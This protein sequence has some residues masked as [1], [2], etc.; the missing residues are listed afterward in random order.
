MK[1][2]FLVALY[3]LPVISYAADSY[4]P[5]AG[6]VHMP[7]VSVGKDNYEVDMLDQGSLVFK[8][9]SAIPTSTLS[10]STDIYDSASGILHMP[11]VIV[12]SNDY[13]VDMI[14][15][16]ELVFK[17]TSA[18][19]I[20]STTTNYLNGDILKVVEPRDSSLNFTKNKLEIRWKAR[21]NYFLDHGKL[22][23]ID[24]ETSMDQQHVY[25]YIPDILPVLDEYGIAIM[26]IDGCQRPSDGSNGYRWS[27]YIFDLV[28]KYPEYFIPT[29]NG[30]TNNNWLKQKMGEYSSFINQLETEINSNKYYS[31]GELDF[32]HYMS[33]HQCES[34]RNDRDNDI[35][36]D[37]ENG[38]RVFQL[39]SD[40][41]I[42]FVMH[43]EAED[44]ALI[45]LE[46][47]LGEYPKAKVI[48]AHFSQ[49]RHPEKQQNF[50]PEYVHH[51]LSSY[52]NLY[53]DL[54]IGG[55]N[56]KYNCAGPDNNEVLIG[57]TVI[58]EEVSGSQENT[59]KADY[60]KILTEFSDR[61]VYASDYGT[62]RKP[63]PIHLKNKT[64]NFHNIIKNLPE[65]A[66]H[67]IAYKNAWFLL[68][69]HN[70]SN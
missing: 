10:T 57:D 22:P 70:W 12:G 55:P 30:G 35:P 42:P 33:G 27:Y 69:G 5:V 19:Q 59:I 68:T 2:F 32:R 46:K 66:K 47:M 15:Q 49:I 41:G 56:R 13:E 58:W 23:L 31:M 1:P 44:D 62:G 37:G 67:N 53:Y 8:V 3:I 18:T 38:H 34:G 50:T 17:L 36:L 28:N 64:S 45:K 25:D 48:V 7:I 6:I 26:S 16:G 24:M 29:A 60:S 9:T 21:I 65:E 61:F 52:P 39:S 11:L 20:D 4:D 14:H 40:T 51:L 54:A 43:L 63:L